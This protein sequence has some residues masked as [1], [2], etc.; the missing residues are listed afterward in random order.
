LGD[1]IVRRNDKLVDDIGANVCP[2]EHHDI[3]VDLDRD[4]LKLF[5][6]KMY[7]EAPFG[8]FSRDQ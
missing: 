1:S 4:I 6:N 3:Q 5:I 8:V 7:F 2:V